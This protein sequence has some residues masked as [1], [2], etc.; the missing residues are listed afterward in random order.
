MGRNGRVAS[1][2]GLLRDVND[3]IEEIAQTFDRGFDEREAGEADFLCEC[4]RENCT[5]SVR[6]SVREYEG[7]RGEEDLF[8]VFP[9]H[10]D[11]AVEEVIIQHE[12]YTIVRKHP[13][14]A[15][16]AHETDPRRH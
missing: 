7:A 13:D 15:A 4:G 3:R 1:N 8:I 16:I 11:L 2:E 14:E 12:R 10:A 9:G 5:E 6:M